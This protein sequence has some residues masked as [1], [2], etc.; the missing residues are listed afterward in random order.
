VRIYVATL[1]ALLITACSSA[2]VVQTPPPQPLQNAD[3]VVDKV[4][5]PLSRTETVNASQE[6][7]T[8]GMRPVVVTAKRRVG[9]TVSEIVIDVYCAPR[10]KI[11]LN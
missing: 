6:C 11:F 9:T 1:T 7:E 4:A 10:Y 3:I 2:P 5:Y 8:G